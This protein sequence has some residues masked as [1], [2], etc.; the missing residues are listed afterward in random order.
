MDEHASRKSAQSEV[1][2]A[3]FRPLAIAA[4]LAL[5]ASLAGRL[6]PAA[7]AQNDTPVEHF[8]YGSVGIEDNEGLPYWIWQVLPLAFRDKLPG[9]GYASLGILWEPGRELPIGF[10]K[11]DVVVERVAINCAFCHT[12]SVRRAAGERP[13]LYPGGPANLTDPQR[14]V[15][16]LQ[17]C[18]SDPRFNAGDLLAEIGKIT[19]LSWTDSLLYRIAFIPGTRKALLRQRDEYAWMDSRPNWGPGRIDPFNPVKF[20]ILKQPI[21]E[22]IGNADMVPIW[23]MKPRSGMAL[24][25][26]GLSASLREVVLSSAIGDGASRKSID[27]ASLQ[28]VEEWILSTPPPKYPFPIDAQLASAGSAVFSTNCATCHAFGQPRAGTV[29][30]LEEVGTDRHRLDMWTAGAAR[31]YNAF[32][33]GYDWQFKGFRKTNGYVAPPLDG[34]WI[35][36]PF[37]HNGSVPSL[38]ALVAPPAARP[39]VF[40]RGYDVYDPMTVGFISSGPDAERVGF[41][42]DTTL[43]GN[44]NGGHTWGTELTA[45]DKRALIEYLK[46]M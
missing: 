17:A 23:N 16:F 18:A 10:S 40:Y 21:D 27:L 37:L 43:P 28:R 11:K 1:R 22:T 35:R 5:A 36:A 14:Y 44:G 45:E 7:E 32:A 2:R 33:E 4:A 6:E 46:T 19:S 38:A 13:T 9:Q 39:S 3:S 29:I 26:D 34:V 15:R 30:P 25:W 20:R 31:A 12:T 41:K 42:V 8:K 24:H